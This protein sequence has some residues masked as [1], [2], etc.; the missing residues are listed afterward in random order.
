MKRKFKR[1]RPSPRRRRKKWETKQ[2]QSAPSRVAWD[3]I[4]RGWSS[5]PQTY[6]DLRNELTENADEVVDVMEKLWKASIKFQSFGTVVHNQQAARKPAAAPSQAAPAGAS[7][8]PGGETRS[9]VHGPMIYRAG[10]AKG[11]GKPYQVFGCT[12]PVRNEQCKGQ[13]LN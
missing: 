10:I 4:R 6:L 12:H 7:E 13:F 8:A 2:K 3:S 1:S 5:M 11:S 9:C